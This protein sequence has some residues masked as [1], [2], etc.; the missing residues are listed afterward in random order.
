MPSKSWIFC[1]CLPCCLQ[2]YMLRTDAAC[3]QQ[4][5]PSHCL[6][7]SPELYNHSAKC[8]GHNSHVQ[9]FVECSYKLGQVKDLPTVCLT[10]IYLPGKPFELRWSVY[11]AE[12][13]S[14]CIPV[15]NITWHL[16]P[17]GSCNYLTGFAVRIEYVSAIL[18]TTIGVRIYN[19]RLSQS[20]TPGLDT[21]LLYY[22]C[23]PALL[24][25]VHRVTV[26]SLPRSPSAAKL[27]NHSVLFVK[28]EQHNDDKADVFCNESWVARAT[29]M[30]SPTDRTIN[31]S[32][33]LA[34]DCYGFNGY[35]ISLV[36]YDSGWRHLVIDRATVLHSPNHEKLHRLFTDVG[37]HLITVMIRPYI[38]NTCGCLSSAAGASSLCRPCH[39]TSISP[40]N[41]TR[42]RGSVVDLPCP[43]DSAMWPWL[44]AAVGVMAAVC[45]VVLLFTVTYRVR[46]QQRKL[47]LDNFHLSNVISHS[48]RVEE[49]QCHNTSHCIPAS[50]VCGGRND[51]GDRSD[52]Q[53]G[54][55]VA[56]SDVWSQIRRYNNDYDSSLLDASC[57]TD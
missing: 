27:P 23:F 34:P 1:Y 19:V 31:V 8:P 14:K 39:V 36:K 43:P 50:P 16:P 35:N 24:G 11:T 13:L 37:P 49:F 28:P 52:E 53:T 4:S 55:D 7:E 44:A 45:L 42:G 32:F 33:E 2:V 51:C 40:I 54:S 38:N 17:D 30:P 41:M 25:H 12:H 3:D 48:C 10:S 56:T 5:L 47:R 9:T 18:N 26:W 22:D 21:T 46:R 20:H 29:I 15:F 6:A 57:D